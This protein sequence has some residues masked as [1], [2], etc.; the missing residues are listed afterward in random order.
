MTIS[1]R[2][3][4]PEDDAFLRRL[5]LAT[6]IE[7]LGAETWPEPMRSHLAGVQ[8]TMRRQGVRG[9]YPDGAS[10]IVL[11]DGV[12]AGWLYTAGLPD[13]VWLVEVMVLPERRGQGIGSAAVREAI[14]SAGARPVQLMVNVT[15]TRAIGLYERLGFRRTGGD[16]VQHLMERPAA[17][18]C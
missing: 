1:F 16:E 15:N 9:R 2:Q 13:V 17:Q 8:Y 7:E 14:G 11:A 10:R 12:E 5:I 3:E 6:I 4:T 18:P